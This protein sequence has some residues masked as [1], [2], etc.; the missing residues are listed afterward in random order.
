MNKNNQGYANKSTLK[1]SQLKMVDVLIVK[2][3]KSGSLELY[4]SLR[5]KE[6][7]RRM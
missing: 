1:H 6:S 2:N 5:N 3:T 7:T 4:V